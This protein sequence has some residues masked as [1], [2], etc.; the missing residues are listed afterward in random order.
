MSMTMTCIL[1]YS[2]ISC[3]YA[4][5]VCKIQNYSDAHYIVLPGMRI[6]EY[7]AKTWY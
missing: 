1:V 6:Y 4:Y 5:F 7:I 3:V 2:I